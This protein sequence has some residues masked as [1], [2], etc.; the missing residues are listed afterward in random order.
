[1]DQPATLTPQQPTAV[2]TRIQSGIGALSIEIRWAEPSRG[3]LIGIYQL[4]TGENRI[5]PP[6]DSTFTVSDGILADHRGQYP[7][8][9][10]D[11]QRIRHLERLLIAASASTPLTGAMI[12]TAYGGARID[13]SVDLPA[14]G[15]AALVSI[16]NVDGQLVLRAERDMVGGSLR[17]V[18][19]AYGYDRITWLDPNT[20]LT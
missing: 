20:P 2:L 15:V 19:L 1:M 8:L 14:P 5:I 3:W 4:T 11:L 9:T 18:C 7:R 6:S 13:L 12:I 17:D 16:Y 10:V